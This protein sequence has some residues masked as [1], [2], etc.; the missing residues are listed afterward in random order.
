PALPPRRRRPGAP[1]VPEV[2]AA[3]TT[4]TADPTR[5]ATATDGVTATLGVTGS[6]TDTDGI[7]TLEARLGTTGAFTNITSALANGTYTISAALFQTLN[8]GVA[9]PDGTYS[10]Q[11]R[12]TDTLGNTSAPTTLTFTL[13][14]SVTANLLLDAA[15][16]TGFQGDYRT[17]TQSITLRGT[18]RAGATVVLERQTTASS[19]AGA[20]VRTQITSTTAGANGTYTF[21]L[22]GTDALNVGP[23]GYRVRVTDGAGNTASAAATITLN[24]APLALNP[25]PTPVAGTVGGNQTFNLNTFF[26]DADTNQY[27]RITTNLP[28]NPVIT[29]QLFNGATPTHVANFLAYAN[30]NAYDNSFIHRTDSSPAVVQGGG[31]EFRPPLTA[32]ITN[33]TWA[34]GVATVTTATPHGLKDGQTVTI[35]GV[36]TAGYNGTYTVDVVNATTFRYTLA[37][38]PGGTGNTGTSTGANFAVVGGLLDITNATWAAGVATIT[39][40]T[41][42]NLSVGQVVSINGALSTGT[43]TGFNDGGTIYTV[44]SV[45]N[46][47]TFTYALA[48]NP[49]TYVGGGSVAAGVTNEPWLPNSTGTLALAKRGGNVS[50]GTNQFYFNTG[51][52]SNGGAALDDQGFTVFGQVV[53]NGQATLN[54]IAA[55]TQKD[56]SVANG[57]FGSVPVQ[58]GAVNSLPNATANDL[59]QFTDIS[60]VTAPLT[61]SAVSSNTGVVTATVTNNNMTL[62]FVGS[63]TATVT[64]TATDPD[65]ATVTYQ[66]TVTV[67]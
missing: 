53:G 44:T 14:R 13:A 27:A 26:T 46:P 54:A 37:T 64:A 15:S 30:A 11:V 43:G 9:L 8:G 58:N 32:T 67:P 62:N 10:V 47:T 3:L 48:T 60:V 18:T 28:G 63:G 29:V 34:A 39:T 56:F 31:F 57:A 66:F 20:P 21:S 41:A 12:A 51:D 25:T 49:G 61:Y 42:H 5:P 40:G 50:S 52:N 33:A 7:A 35:A 59:V 6:A 24:Q 55:L 4:D 45:I 23:N 16:D 19:P 36:N 38:D 1:G 2:T 65:G 17:E 22:T